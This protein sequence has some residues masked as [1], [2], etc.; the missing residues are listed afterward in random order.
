M[1]RP[2]NPN[3]VDSILDITT[4]LVA[5]RGAD[6]V[7][8][9]EIAQRAGVTATTIHYYFEDRAGLLEAVKVRAISELNA[10]IAA[11]VDDAASATVQL[12]SLAGTFLSWSL[13]HPHEFAL[14]FEAVPPLDEPCDEL[15][16]QYHAAYARVRRI[17]ER[18][19]RNGEFSIDDVDLQATVGFATI[20]GIVDLYLNKRLPPEYSSDVFQVFDQ[21]VREVLVTLSP[22][23]AAARAGVTLG[24]EAV[25]KAHDAAPSEEVADTGEVTGVVLA[26]PSAGRFAGG[27][28]LD[29]E[30]LEDLAAAGPPESSGYG[31][32]GRSSD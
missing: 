17:Y 8:L 1:T 25:P 11:A 16:Q 10:A 22:T 26:M 15:S 13:D 32:D 21:A 24:D 19:C 20:F 5:E 6:R 3:L 23:V 18:G 7:T 4:D 14:L 2:P 27:R 28:P 30:E 31:F 12:C 29:D 9:R